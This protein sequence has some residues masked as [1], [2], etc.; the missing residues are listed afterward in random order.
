MLPLLSLFCLLPLTSA[1]LSVPP[2]DPLYQRQFR[3]NFQI[4]IPPSRQSQTDGFYSDSTS[5]G[6]HP[7]ADS[8]YSLYNYQSIDWQKEDIKK[9]VIQ[10][11]GQARD[12]CEYNKNQDKRQEGRLVDQ[13]GCGGMGSGQSLD[14]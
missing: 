11:H 2:T 6:P 4:K 1:W 9:V 3:N 8:I 12:A 14:W 13:V 5:T 7:G 10:I